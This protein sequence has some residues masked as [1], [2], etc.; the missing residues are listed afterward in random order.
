MNQLFENCTCQLFREC[1]YFGNE[2]IN[3]QIK[4]WFLIGINGQG[5]ME[6]VA[7]LQDGGMKAGKTK[8]A[9]L[10][11]LSLMQSK[12]QTRYNYGFPKMQNSHDLQCTLSSER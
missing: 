9:S 10:K 11:S 6:N 3:I 8:P 7:C 12:G 2:Y 5:R 4:I 1:F